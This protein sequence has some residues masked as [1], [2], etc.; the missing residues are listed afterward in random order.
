MNE[1]LPSKTA[2]RNEYVD[3]PLPDR[4]LSERLIDIAEGLFDRPERSF[5]DSYDAAGLEGAYRFFRNE[6][7]SS[8]KILVPHQLETAKRMAQEPC[9]LALHDTTSFSFPTTSIRKGLGRKRSSGQCFFAHTT[10]AVSADGTRRPLGVLALSTFTRDA[11]PSAGREA[12]RWLKQIEDVAELPN[13]CAQNV[14]HVADR[15]SDSFVTLH[16]LQSADARF[17]LR[18]SK[19]RRVRTSAGAVSKLDTTLSKAKV[20]FKRQASLSERK[21]VR[22]SP[23]QTKLHPNRAARLAELHVSA[24]SIELLRPESYSNKSALPKSL[25]VHVVRVW[26]PAPPKGENAVEWLL[27]TSEPIQTAT[28]LA[29]IIDHYRA[30]WV[31][32]EYFKALKSGCKLE[33]RQLE[34]LHALRNALAVFAPIAWNLLRLRTSAREQPDAPAKDYISKNELTVL[35][36][37]SRIPLKRTPTRREALLAIAALGGHIK[38]NGEPGWITLNRGY[39][40]LTAMV[41]GFKIGRNSRKSY[42]QS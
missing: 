15:E 33:E 19:D 4:R 28:D 42:D 1:R 31:I 18:V 10:L 5:P 16:A 34:S 26:E 12:G 11:K 25:T 30:R 29:A 3:S 20:I 2:L 14:I 6:R 8:E 41:E 36:Q 24:A 27:F 17:V 7:V 9:V 23:I 22:P 32:E 40:K 38:F 21:T 35:R 37:I 39:Q 13:V